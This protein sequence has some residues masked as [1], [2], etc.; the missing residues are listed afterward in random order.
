MKRNM[1]FA[2]VTAVL[3]TAE[4][5]WL[6]TR[7]PE[8]ST[9]LALDQVNGGAANA[10]NL[11]EFE[12]LKDLA[13][14]MTAS[15]ILGTGLLLVDPWVRR[16]WERIG[17]VVSKNT[18]GSALPLLFSLAALPLFSG[19]VRPYDRPEYVEIDTSETG[20]LIPLEGNGSEQVK[21]QSEDYLN[22]VLLQLKSLEVE[23]ARIEKWDGRYPQMWLGGAGGSPNLLFQVPTPAV[24]DSLRQAAK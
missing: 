21:F 1:I 22:P 10:R 9:S 19:C 11:R 18:S 24:P 13:H 8:I 7:Q 15:L 23:K 14:G 2:L 20:F 4:T 6:A 12:S 17:R 5:L 16:G 3:W